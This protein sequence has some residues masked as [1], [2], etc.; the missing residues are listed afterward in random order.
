MPTLPQLQGLNLVGAL[1][2]FNRGREV[3]IERRERNAL[4][5]FGQ[6]AFQGDQ[7]ALNQLFQTNPRAAFQLAQINEQRGAREQQ[8]RL[9]EARI[10][11]LN[12]K[13]N[14][15]ALIKNLEAAGIDPRS[16]EGRKIIAG[17]GRTNVTV[18][19]T[20]N[21]IPLPKST[22]NKV[23]QQV[24]S[25]VD[26][27]GRLDEIAETFDPDFLTFAGQLTNL[28]TSF[29]SKAGFNVS[30]EQRE[31]LA[32]YSGFVQDSLRNVNQT[33]KDITGAAMGV[34]EA[35]R[36]IATL[37]NTGDGSIGSILSGNF[38]DP[39]AFKSKLFGAIQSVKRSI[40][41]KNFLL[42][43]GISEKPWEH[44][45][46]EGIDQI[47]SDREAELVEAA[48]AQGLPDELIADQV[49]QQLRQEFGI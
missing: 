40:A 23:T 49:R 3:G 24:V 31:A 37:P 22:Q 44:M 27:I 30:P 21:N 19:P 1:N 18:N 45:P 29:K 17:Q 42:R 8:N 7:N 4:A 39:I 35:K 28:V 6:A 20:I 32:Q 10:D 36:I 26:A 2:E 12:N 13:D 11:A 47:M 41:R 38:D 16:P 48:R 34:E 5:E 9:V 25:D 43:Q 46:L 14:R 33:I 15:T